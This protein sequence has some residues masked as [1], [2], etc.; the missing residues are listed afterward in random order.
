MKK[1]YIDFRKEHLQ[2]QEI[3]LVIKEGNKSVESLRK[4][5]IRVCGEKN[6]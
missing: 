3:K 2:D 1:E 6:I 4:R 5:E